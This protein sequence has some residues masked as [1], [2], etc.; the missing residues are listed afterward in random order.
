M[1]QVRFKIRFFV[2]FVLLGMMSGLWPATAQNWAKIYTIGRL[3][4]IVCSGDETKLMVFQREFNACVSS[5]SGAT[6][7]ELA[8]P[9]NQYWLSAGLSQDGKLLI[10]TLRRGSEPTVYT[11]TNL[12][13]TWIPGDAPTNLNWTFVSC[14][15]DG[16]RMTIGGYTYTIHGNIPAPI[17]G[18]TDFGIHWTQI[19]DSGVAYCSGDGTKLFQVDANGILKVSANFGQNWTPT[20]TDANGLAACSY[21]GTT[22]YAG[23][24]TNGIDMIYVSHDSGFNWSQ[25]ATPAGIYFYPRACSADGA[26]VFASGNDGNVYTSTNSGVTWASNSIPLPAQGVACSSDA[27]K[28][29]AFFNVGDPDSGFSGYVFTPQEALLS[30][31]PAGANVILSWPASYLANFQLEEN[32]DTATTNWTSVAATPEIVGNYFQVTNAA[33]G[34]GKF[35]RLKSQ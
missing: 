20:L 18:S 5:N 31:A 27:A 23:A 10:A 6:W 7:T 1:K 29:Y 4:K 24:N 30:I 35:F 26:K 28:V 17:Y 15:A 11:S 2:Y 34:G 25:A 3:D 32:A 14:S 33:A 22:V 12:G 19:A 8:K 16:S 21:D 13:A 9:N